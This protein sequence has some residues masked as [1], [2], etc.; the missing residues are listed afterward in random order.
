MRSDHLTDPDFVGSSISKPE[1]PG[2]V[3][4]LFVALCTVSAF[5][6]RYLTLPQ[7]AMINGDGVFYASF[8]SKLVSGN[9]IDGISTYWSPLYS[10]VLGAVYL[11]THDL[12]SAGRAVSMVAG[13]LL[14]VPTFI[15][16]RKFFGD[17]SAFI[18]TVLVA[19]HP[20]LIT[21]SGWVMTE[22]LYGLI[23]LTAVI[24]GWFALENG[25]LVTFLLTGCLY[26]AAYLTKP[27]FTGFV[28]LYVLLLVVKGLMQHRWDFRRLALGSLVFLVG[29]GTFFLPYVVFIHHKTGQWTLSQKLVSNSRFDEPGQGMLKLIDGGTKTLQD[30]IWWDKYHDE[31]NVAQVKP[32]TGGVNSSQNRAGFNASDLMSRAGKNLYKQLTDYMRTLFPLSFLLLGAIGFVTAPWT[33]DR[34]IKDIYL[35]SF[36]ACTFIGYAI[37][38]TELRYTFVLI[39]ILLGWVGL[40]CA[41]IG[42]FVAE[43]LP[44]WKGAGRIPT[45]FVQG[46][47]LLLLIASLAPLF[48]R[49]MEGRDLDNVPYEEKAAGLWLRHNSDPGSIVMSPDAR[50]AFYAGAEHIFLP[51]EDVQTIREYAERRNVTYIVL[52]ERRLKNRKS[53]YG[54]A[55]EPTGNLK[56]IYDDVIQD[57]FNVKIYKV[58]K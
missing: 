10:S 30:R 29:F 47:L 48:S 50:V 14:I 21:S 18:G 22:S 45:A 43:R 19:L 38:V 51:D 3:A 37:T 39:P 4:G 8:G 57:G 16:I 58:E 24:C 7:N 20:L 5:L 26:G 40:G 25:K 28:A 54:I 17:A 1:P 33:K 11:L 42:Q 31:A 36:V 46:S 55:D 41:N 49:E 44:N 15:L 35:L 9:L 2:R 27:E 6:V 23:F 53:V 32:E 13:S 56:I 12:E 34:A 52:S